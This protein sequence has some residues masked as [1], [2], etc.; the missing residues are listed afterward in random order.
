MNTESL[1]VFFPS[2]D[3]NVTKDY[4]HNILGLPIYKDLGNTVWFDTGYGYVAFVEYSPKRPPASGM[5]IS[6]NLPTKED[7]D[8]MYDILRGRDVIGLKEPPKKHPQFPV[9]SFFLSDPDGYTLEYQKT[10]D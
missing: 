8:D 7:V 5:C 9:Y 3:I 4:Y 2:A 1:T 6:F 10:A